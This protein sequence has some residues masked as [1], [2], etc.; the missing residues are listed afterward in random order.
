[1]TDW[2]AEAAHPPRGVRLV[3]DD[4][5]EFSGVLL[6]ER[7]RPIMMLALRVAAA[8]CKEPSPSPLATPYERPRWSPYDE[9]G[10]I[11]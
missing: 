6:V 2:L 3:A 9:N 7:N 11:R 8:Q 1:M 4:G 5:A 10:P